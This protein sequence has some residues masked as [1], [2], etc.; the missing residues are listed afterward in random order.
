MKLRHIAASVV[1]MLCAAVVGSPAAA[2]DGADPEP[3]GPTRI[4]W[5]NDGQTIDDLRRKYRQP[6]T[7]AEWK[8]AVEATKRNSTTPIF[9]PRE[10]TDPTEFPPALTPDGNNPAPSRGK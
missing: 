4:G 2:S 5:H 9:D 1:I 8:A 6:L 3:D 7:E 10:P